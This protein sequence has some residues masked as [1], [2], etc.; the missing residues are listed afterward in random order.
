MR[1]VMFTKIL[2]ITIQKEIKKVL[3]VLD[4]LFADIMTNKKFQAI[5]LAFISQ[6]S[7]SVPK[8]A[9]LNTTHYFIMKINNRIELKNIVT[10]HSADIDYQD[11]KKIYRECTKEPFNFLT[12]D[13][14]L[15]TSDPLRFRKNLFDY[16][17]NDNS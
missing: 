1:W 12:I 14:P 11:F 7:F 5:S 3:I 16:Y 8:D 6:S 13:T 17:K 15:P 10:D 2:I 9:R 4:D